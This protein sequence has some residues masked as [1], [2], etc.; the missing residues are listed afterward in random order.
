MKQNNKNFNI[1]GLCEDYYKFLRDRIIW[2]GGEIRTVYA[3]KYVR[4]HCARYWPLIAV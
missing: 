1:P 2:K 4:R 3:G